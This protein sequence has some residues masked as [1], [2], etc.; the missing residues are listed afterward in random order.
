MTSTA[1]VLKKIQLICK[2]RTACWRCGGLD[3]CPL[4]PYCDGGFFEKL[5][6]EEL[7]EM[8]DIIDEWE[9]VP[10]KTERKDS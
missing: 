7:Q 3:V 1:K 5:T 4:H 8:A 10:K 2:G 6:D 9:E